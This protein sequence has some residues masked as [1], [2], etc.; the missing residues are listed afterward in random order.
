MAPMSSHGGQSILRVALHDRPAVV[1]KLNPTEAHGALVE[2]AAGLARL[3]ATKTVRVPDVLFIGFA[4]DQS[5]L[6][7][8]AF[9]IVRA[10][11]AAWA[12]FGRSLAALHQT[13][14]GARYGFDHDNHCGPTPQCNDWCDDWVEFNRR[15]RLGAQCDLAVMRGVLNPDEVRAVRDLIEHLDH[16]VPAHPTPALLHGDLWSGNALPADDGDGG[17]DIAVIDPACSIGDGW[18]DI[19]M[20]RLFGGF[21]RICEQAYAEC[22]EVPDDVEQRILVYQLYHLL[23]HLNLFGRGYADQVMSHVR[24]LR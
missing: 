3:R 9:E 19:A 14:A 23:N 2:E 7:M 8:E 18:A 24:R 21:P 13:S 1:I 20:M 11:E 17:C 15:H 16:V 22:I 10:D 12:R 6:I 4:C 5:A